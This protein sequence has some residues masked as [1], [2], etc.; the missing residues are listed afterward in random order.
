[1]NKGY[2]VGSVFLAA[3]ALASLF[4]YAFGL[5]NVTDASTIM[6]NE[7]KAY[8]VD[9]TDASSTS[10]ITLKTVA[11][12]VGSVIV[13]QGSGST[14]YSHLTLY[15]ATSSQPTTTARVLAKFGTTTGE[16]LGTYQFDMEFTSGLRIEVPVGFNGYY[17]VTYR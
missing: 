8:L 13:T 3:V 10:P 5:L 9:S 16:A 1:M 12:S 2:S 14:G 11:G 17:T 7:Y 15:D 4:V 6:G